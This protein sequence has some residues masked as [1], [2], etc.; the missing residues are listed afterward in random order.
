[1]SARAETSGFD[2]EA[3][4]SLAPYSDELLTLAS[5]AID[6]GLA[7]G[8]PPAVDPSQHAPALREQRAAFV[9]LLDRDGGLRGCIGSIEAQRPLATDVSA[10]AFAAAFRDPRFPPLTRAEWPAIQC[11]LSVLTPFERMS[12]ADELDLIDQLEPGH[13][14]VLIEAG[15]RRGTLLPQVW[16]DLP[17]PQD[18]WRTLKRKAG[19][20]VDE[21]PRDLRAYRYRAESIG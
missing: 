20:G 16:A 18:F 2:S 13:D 7:H 15:Q 21:W 9:T 1:M 12:F 3:R 6:H 19:L 5:E 8:E 14:G 11:K 17:N 4:P 10:N